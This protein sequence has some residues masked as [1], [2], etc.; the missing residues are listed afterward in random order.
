MKLSYRQ[1]RHVITLLISILA[2]PITNTMAIQ[3]DKYS[4][5]VSTFRT[6]CKSAGIVGSSF[7]FIKDNKVISEVHYGAL[8]AATNQPVSG[9]NHLSLGVE[10]KAV[11]RHRYNAAPRPR[12]VEA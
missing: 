9:D 1:F 10:Y 5:F 4:Q 2:S 3:T 12:A 7:V 11:H 8:N 6:E